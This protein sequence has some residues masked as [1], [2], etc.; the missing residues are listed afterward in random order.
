[1]IQASK[2]NADIFLHTEQMIALTVHGQHQRH[3]G[4]LEMTPQNMFET[5]S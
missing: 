3:S 5:Q 2:V 1:V 4:N